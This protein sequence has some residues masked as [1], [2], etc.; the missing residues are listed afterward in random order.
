L[1]YDRELS[2]KITG[3]DVRTLQEALK[4]MKY[5]DIDNC[6][7]YYGAQTEE[8]LKA[9]QTSQGLKAD[10]IA[11]LRTIEAIN[12]VLSGRGIALPEPTR[13]S[14][15]RSVA[16]NIIA[17][18]KKYIGVPYSFGGTSPKGFDCS[19]FT[20]YVY[21]QH[22]ISV[23]RDTNGQAGAGTKVSKVDLKPGDLL[24]FSNTYKTGPS[25]AGI[26]MGNGQFVHA[27]TTRSG[28]V[29]ISDLN[30]NY[31]ANHFSYGRRVF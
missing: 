15:T 25:H 5:L 31:Y 14:E 26:Y 23:P 6:T 10:G 22:G 29:I 16:T 11:G 2:L 4:A 20:S 1:T 21:K 13:G 7:D 19:G 17:T 8:A 27:S 28:G 18:G 30:S 12:K 9:F 24:I 3:E